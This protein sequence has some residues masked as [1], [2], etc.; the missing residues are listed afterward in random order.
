MKANNTTDQK[1]KRELAQIHI[2]KIQLGLDDDTYRDILWNIAQVRSSRDLNQAS[3]KRVLE[4]LTAKGWQK[5]K[6]ARAQQGKSP[7]TAIGKA[8][9]MS[10]IGALLTEMQLPWT[11]ANGISQQMF[12]VERVDWCT[13]QQLH[14][15]VAALTYKAQKQ[16]A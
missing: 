1:R 14:K 12:K 16:N 8:P 4:H 13:P 6:P 10:K 15:L 7:T 3:R 11:Y 2:A 5:K 9:L